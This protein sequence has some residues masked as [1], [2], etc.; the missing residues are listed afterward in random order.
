MSQSSKLVVNQ[1]C[2]W[3]HWKNGKLVLF[4]HSC[5]SFKFYILS[6]YIDQCTDQAPLPLVRIWISAL[7]RQG[8]SL[9]PRV[10]SAL[11]VG[12]T[13]IHRFEAHRSR[14]GLLSWWGIQ[15]LYVLRRYSLQDEQLNTKDLRSG[16]LFYLVTNS[17]FFLTCS[18]MYIFCVRH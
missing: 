15:K 7:W 10:A 4:N 13:C 16:K 11:L 14:S 12:T 18:Y 1:W 2:C 8:T 3:W 17:V 5:Q 9:C 6:T